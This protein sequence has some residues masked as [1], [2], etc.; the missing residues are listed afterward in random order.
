[1][2]QHQ[3]APIALHALLAESKGFVSVFQLDAVLALL[4]QV[5]VPAHLT[6]SAVLK[7]LVRHLKEP[8]N[9]C[10]RAL[11]VEHPTL[12]TVPVHQIFNAVLVPLFLAILTAAPH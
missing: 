10:R 11:A 1:M 2:I 8:V 6:L 12:A 4:P 7:I 5:F 3:T 9:A